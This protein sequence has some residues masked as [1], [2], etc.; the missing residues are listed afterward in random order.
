MKFKCPKCG[1]TF[2]RDMRVGLNK[3]HFN[4]GLF[5]SYC[6]K[7]NTMTNCKPLKGG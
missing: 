1:K 3:L 5:F 6:D 2:N 7:T 4:N